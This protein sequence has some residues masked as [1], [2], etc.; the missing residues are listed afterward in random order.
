[1]VFVD[2]GRFASLPDDAL[3]SLDLRIGTELAAATLDRLQHLA[4]VTAAER[5]ALKALARR[6]YARAD[7][8]RRLTRKGH[9]RPAVARALERLAAH[10]LMDDRRFAVEYARARTKRGSARARIVRDLLVQG[11]ERATAEEAARIGLEV[12]GTDPETAA[13]AI[14]LRR[15]RQLGDLAPAVR[16]RRLLAF[17]VR[18]GYPGPQVKELVEELA[19]PAR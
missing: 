19:G 2:R 17:L 12:E 16:K 10:G 9:Q 6:A 13:R 4:D 14:A 5:A 1:M 18:R 3:A 11:V 15:A 8:A 7:L